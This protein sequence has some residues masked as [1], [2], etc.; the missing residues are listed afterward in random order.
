MLHSDRLLSVYAYLIKS[1]YLATEIVEKVVY[2]SVKMYVVVVSDI[3]H[4]VSC[5]KT[6]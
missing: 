6:Q 1:Y 4:L 5:L 2:V 3:W